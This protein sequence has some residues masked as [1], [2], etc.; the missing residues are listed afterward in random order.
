MKIQADTIIYSVSV[1][2]TNITLQLYTSISHVRIHLT[3]YAKKLRKQLNVG[4]MA[5]VW[6]G[7]HSHEKTFGFSFHISNIL[8]LNFV[9]YSVLIPWLFISLFCGYKSY[10][11]ADELHTNK[12]IYSLVH[13]LGYW[14]LEAQLISSVPSGFVV[15]LYARKIVLSLE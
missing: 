7:D 15:L 11:F 4:I 5:C 3:K 9:V 6:E 8:Y 12:S 13:I 14:I 2:I 1:S 10:R